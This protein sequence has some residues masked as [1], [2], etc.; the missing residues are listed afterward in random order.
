MHLGRYLAIMLLAMAAVVV[1]GLA[2]CGG[3]DDD[4]GGN[5]PVASYL[6]QVGALAALANVQIAGLE[7]RHPGAFE[8]VEATKRYYAEYVG[9]YERFLDSTKELP[10]PDE[11]A[12][13]HGEYVASSEEILVL[14]QARNRELSAATTK[15]EMDAILTVDAA[16]TA[17]VTRRDAA[18][19]ELK[20]LADEKAVNVAG[21]EG[22]IIVK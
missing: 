6:Q 9:I 19:Q 5:D 13:E 11:V 18:C 20:A 14:L 17:A 1:L 3:D 21:L 10:V 4:A 2:S 7:A 12:D 22:C 8:D 15:E 16:L